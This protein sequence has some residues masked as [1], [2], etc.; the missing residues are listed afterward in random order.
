MQRYEVRGQPLGRA[1][2]LRGVWREGLVHGVAAYEPRESGGAVPPSGHV[3]LAVRCAQVGSEEFQAHGS[4][5]YHGENC[6]GQAAGAAPRGAEHEIGL[7]QRRIRDTSGR[8]HMRSSFSATA[9]A[10]GAQEACA[11]NSEPEARHA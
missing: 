8:Y 10:P 11:H 2:Q 6:H 1:W 3:R 9:S 7:Q 5:E 4:A